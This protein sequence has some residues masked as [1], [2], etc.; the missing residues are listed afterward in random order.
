MKRSHRSRHFNSRSAEIFEC[1][2]LGDGKQ[3]SD[4]S[5]IFVSYHST[6]QS[7]NRYHEALSAVLARNPIPGNNYWAEHVIG[8]NP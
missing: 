5:G 4:P 1:F 6:G 2:D 3:S 7:S 8:T